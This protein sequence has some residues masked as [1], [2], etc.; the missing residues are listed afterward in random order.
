MKRFLI[1]LSVIIFIS[2][3]AFWF[4]SVPH[5]WQTEIFRYTVFGIFLGVAFM[6]AL[7]HMFLYAFVAKERAYLLFSAMCIAMLLRY[8][9]MEGGLVSLLLDEYTWQWQRAS[10]CALTIHAVFG[11][12]FS[13]VALQLPFT[14]VRGVGYA[15]C[16]GVSFFGPFV[17]VRPYYLLFGIVPLVGIII[18]ALREQK[19]R[20]DPYRVT[21]VVGVMLFAL[22]TIFG[23]TGIFRQLFMMGFF[24][25]L[26]FFFTQTVLLSVEFS[27]TRKRESELVESNA[28]LE[29][30]SRV[31]SE[32]FSNISHEIK[33]PLTVIATDIALTQKYLQRGEI[34]EA[35]ELLDNAHSEVMYTANFVADA[36]RFSRN[37]ETVRTAEWFDFGA[38]IETTVAVFG[39]FAQLRGNKLIVEQIDAVPLD[40]YGNA[41]ALGSAMV[42][43][44]TNANNH[45][46]NGT[47]S[48]SRAVSDS[49]A[50]I[51][52]RDN[53]TGIAPEMLPHV[54]ERGVTDGGGT[55]LGLPIVKSIMQQYG[56]EVSI[57]SKCGKGTVVTCS[58]PLQSEV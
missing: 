21:Y 34:N 3:S 20:S 18:T 43:L 48:I 25:W 45:T 7:Y 56:G 55:G 6:M 37:Q 10:L 22:W 27:E 19:V 30:L 13:N 1:T 49:C 31:K 33:T 50:V 9:L 36:L 29:N 42:N 17:F 14:K 39:P 24:P 26:F 2:A 28:L 11:I 41:D 4:I 51:S 47:I 44:L 38:V 15:L 5:E 52:V 35:L 57:E 32:F 12:W 16:F 58:I 46:Q 8:V 53:G 54:F 40:I 23:V